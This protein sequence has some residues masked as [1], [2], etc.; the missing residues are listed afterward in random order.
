MFCRPNGKSR[1]PSGRGHG[2]GRKRRSHKEAVEVS[3]VLDAP[4]KSETPLAVPEKRALVEKVGPEV[5]WPAAHTRESQERNV[6]VAALEEVMKA[7]ERKADERQERVREDLKALERKA[8]ERQERV[9]EDL[10]ALGQVV[11]EAVDRVVRRGQEDGAVIAAQRETVDRWKQEAGGVVEELRRLTAGSAAVSDVRGR[12][13]AQVKGTVKKKKLET[14]VVPVVVP[15]SHEAE[16]VY[17]S[18][19]TEGGVPP[20]EEASAD[21]AEGSANSG[22][23]SAACSTGSGPAPPPAYKKPGFLAFLLDV[24]LISKGWHV[25]VLSFLC[26]YL[27]LLPF[28]KA[29]A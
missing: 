23:A 28:T 5:G 3:G 27:M 7:L 10:K 11:R 2:H 1:P 8:D 9:R 29:K 22:E 24:S 21:Q 20:V 13:E 12:A 14:P 18:E 26:G 25:P 15:D 6:S 17:P 16:K 4:K 19:E